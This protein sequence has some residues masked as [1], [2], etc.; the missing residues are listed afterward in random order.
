ME[1]YL[2]EPALRSMLQV[3]DMLD[4]AILTL[5][6]SMYFIFTSSYFRR[7]MARHYSEVQSVQQDDSVIEGVSDQVLV[8]VVVSVALIASLLYALLR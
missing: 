1:L 7:V 3:L 8:A 4:I 5:F 6:S 2:A